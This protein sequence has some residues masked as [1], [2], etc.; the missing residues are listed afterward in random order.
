MLVAIVA[1]HANAA[2]TD[3]S[4]CKRYPS[5]EKFSESGC[6]CGADLTKLKLNVRPP[7]GLT[8]A[9]ACNYKKTGNGVSGYFYFEGEAVVSG[10]V[11]TLEGAEGHFLLFSRVPRP[12]PEQFSSA[13]NELRIEDSAAF[14]LF[15]TPTISKK[16]SCWQAN[17]KIKVTQLTVMEGTGSSEEG[18][19]PDQYDVLEVGRYSQCKP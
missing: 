7:T 17:A 8:L 11:I 10:T 13:M 5:I 19:F 4:A 6:K 16:T 14:K 1:S 3:D 2:P 18:S 12:P 15:K 9:A